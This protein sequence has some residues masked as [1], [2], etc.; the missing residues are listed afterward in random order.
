MRLQR[1][2]AGGGPRLLWNALLC[3]SISFKPVHVCMFKKT[4]LIRIKVDNQDIK[5]VDVGGRK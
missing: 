1:I 4:W 2:S 5:T 3:C